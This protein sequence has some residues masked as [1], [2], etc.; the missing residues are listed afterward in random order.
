MNPEFMRESTSIAD[1][2][3]PPMTLVGCDDETLSARGCTPVACGEGF[4]FA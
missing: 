3:R 2:H 1:F 4:G